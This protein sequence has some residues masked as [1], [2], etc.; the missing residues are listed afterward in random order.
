MHLT[1]KHHFHGP[2][3]TELLDQVNAK[4]GQI[5]QSALAKYQAILKATT[6]TKVAPNLFVCNYYIDK[7]NWDVWME[8]EITVNLTQI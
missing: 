6:K 1:H 7:D 3:L 2:R 5:D 4:P 8:G